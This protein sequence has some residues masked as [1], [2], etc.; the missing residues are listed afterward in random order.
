MPGPRIFARFAGTAKTFYLRKRM[1]IGKI[2]AVFQKLRGIKKVF[3]SF[4]GNYRF[5]PFRVNLQDE[6]EFSLK[7]G[8]Q[9]PRLYLG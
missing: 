5:Q 1:S 6:P 3:G 4:A 2:E 7:T 9:N 8:I